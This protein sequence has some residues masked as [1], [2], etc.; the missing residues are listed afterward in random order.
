MKELVEISSL[1]STT[2]TSDC[3]IASSVSQAT[4]EDVAVAISNLSSYL[5]AIPDPPDS[6][7]PL[8]LYRGL[9]NGIKGLIDNVSPM[10]YCHMCLAIIKGICT[11]ASSHLPYR[12]YQGKYYALQLIVN[13]H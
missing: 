11:L 8:Y 2:T 3:D 5:I 1:L 13:Q 7:N 9:V 4:V 10:Y 6:S 12:L